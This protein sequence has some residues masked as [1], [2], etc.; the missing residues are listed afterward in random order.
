MQNTKKGYLYLTIC[1]ASWA[2]IPIASKEILSN[3]DNIQMLFYSSV[4]STFVLFLFVIFQKKIKLL[5]SYKLED[6]F[7]M[8]LIGFIGIYFNYLMLYK[9]F[10]IADAAVVF[11]LNYTWPVF[12]F[13]FSIF[14]FKEKLTIRK[15]FAIL[16][17]F[18]GITVII[19][20]GNIAKINFGNIE[21]D[22]FAILAALSAATYSIIG[23]KKNFEKTTSVFF[24]FLFVL[25]FITPT[26]FILS[27]FKI[28]D[29][30]SLFWLFINGTFINGIS[31]IFW[32]KALEN[33]KTHIISNAIYLTPFLSLIYLN[34]FLGQKIFISSVIGLMFIA[35]SIIIVSIKPHALD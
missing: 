7:Y 10:S 13:I 28:P 8:A 35:S 3:L 22:F 20:K 32:F 27:S 25:F 30:K 9:A 19:T 34:I 23:K 16:I 11:I 18:F 31:F 4:I 33:L 2:L 15:I 17:S 29:I 6:Y 5:F 12:L 1:I 24:Y 21:G 26:L 14:V